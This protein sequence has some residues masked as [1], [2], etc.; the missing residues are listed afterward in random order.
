MAYIAGIDL[1]A[2]ATKTVI[3]DDQRNI[4]GRG[5]IKTK[6]NFNV[7]AKQSIEAACE[8]A[9]LCMEDIDYIASTG[10]GRY[11]LGIRD[12]QITDLTCGARGAAA[13]FPAVGVGLLPTTFPVTPRLLSPK[14]ATNPPMIT[15]AIK[16]KVE[17]F[18]KA[19]FLIVI[20]SLFSVDCFSSLIISS[21][22]FN[23]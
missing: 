13:L 19:S 8:E 3:M 2:G 23:F 20:V 14:K 16:T 4:V 17:Y 18:H 22:P 11:S 7:V 12:I 5:S 1:G 10:L 9:G 6:A 15:I 21:P